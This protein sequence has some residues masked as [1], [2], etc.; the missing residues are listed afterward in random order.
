M[1]VYQ[2]RIKLYVLKDIPVERVQEK[3]AQ[4]IDT[5]FAVSRELLQMHEENRFKY[6]CFDS[7]YP[8]EKDKVYRQGCIYTVTIRTIERKLADY[9]Y[10]I[11]VNHFTEDFKGLT[12][13][14]RILPH[15]MIEYLYTLTPAVLKENELGY[16]R[17]HMSLQRFEERLKINLIKKWNQFTGEQVEEDFTLFTVLEF[18]N[19]KPV[20]MNYKT[21]RLL[22]D[23]I[24]LQITEHKTSQQLAYM[25]L[26]T[27]VLEMNSRGAGFV[28]CRWM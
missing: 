13:E 15:K 25:A 27:G 10:E 12:A 9:F 11:C 23:K 26:G 17:K 14:I 1:Q 4:F 18:L 19:V 21:V 7:L 2:I 6:Y 28:N 3:L 24:R 20:A 16:W 5:G 8:V 22:G